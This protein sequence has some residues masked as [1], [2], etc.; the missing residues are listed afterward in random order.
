[1][2]EML[3]SVFQTSPHVCE[4][5]LLSLLYELETGSAYRLARKDDSAASSSSK[6]KGKKKLAPAG[7]NKAA[8]AAEEEEI[9]EL[10]DEVPLP[11]T[12]LETAAGSSAPL[13][14]TS[15][16]SSSSSSAA[17]S[18]SSATATP[19]LS[20]TTP[21]AVSLA[22]CR[23]VFLNGTVQ[24]LA[25]K[26]AP[27]LSRVGLSRWPA[28]SILHLTHTRL[29]VWLPVFSFVCCCVRSR[30]ASSFDRVYLSQFAVGCI[31]ETAAARATQ[32]A[33]ALHAGAV[34]VDK[35]LEGSSP[36]T[37]AS[38]AAATTA[39]DPTAP[40]SLPLNKLIKPNAVITV[41]TVKS[42][43]QSRGSASQSSRARVARGPARRASLAVE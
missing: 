16:S 30:Y 32:E 28:S 25:T 12:L 39:I 1:M 22:H 23:L 42:V 9:V 14:A 36:A 7:T 34:A 33:K 26:S 38:A 4:Y 6:A 31:N 15:A 2:L 17:A 41:E 24:T 11:L 18:S 40:D 35:M 8:A 13:Q 29:C 3:S 37:A 27:L 21:N 20:H 43:R 5:N 10:P 19:A